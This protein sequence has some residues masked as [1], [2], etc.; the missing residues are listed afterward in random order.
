[1]S[2]AIK[3]LIA[4][5]GLDG[6]EAGALLVARALRDAGMEVIYLGTRQTPETIV[7]SALQEN[8]GIIGLSVLSG[9]HKE[10]ARSVLKLL[11]G[12][13]VEHVSLIIGGIVPNEDIVELKEM[14]VK[15]IF[16]PGTDTRDIVK[17]I[18]ELSSKNAGDRNFP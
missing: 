16:G 8:V 11:K 13:G 12:R 18:T 15:A 4:K 10:A 6:H 9:I 17:Q 2:K 7:N 3:V 14:G 1:M 5:P